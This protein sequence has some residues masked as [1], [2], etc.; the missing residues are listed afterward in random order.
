MPPEL[1]FNLADIDLSRIVV[2]KEGIRKI[3]PQRF[4][5]EQLDAIVHLDLNL[6]IIVGYKNV[7]NDE[8]WTR[9]HMPGHPLMPGVLMCEAAA[10]LSSYYVASQIPSGDFIGFA[11]LEHVRFRG[12]VH[13]GDRLVLVGK[14]LKI[15]RR[16]TIFNV[17]GF[18]KSTMVFHGDFLGVPMIHAREKTT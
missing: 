3:L 4:E 1:H 5:M 17:Q 15:H 2:D 7:S 16:Q 10:Q 11:G 18:V 8:F 6:Q 13:P 14:A 9:G 12:T